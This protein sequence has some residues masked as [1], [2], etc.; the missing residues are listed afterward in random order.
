MLADERPE[1]DLNTI[2]KKASEDPKKI[3]AE[4]K[5]IKGLGDIGIDIFF[6]IAQHVWPCLGPWIDPRS[7]G[8]AEKI[9][10]GDEVQA[11]WKIVG[12]E[13]E[14]MCRLACALT[15]VRLER[16]ESEWA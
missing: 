5:T 6:T 7:L 3:R 14:A 4:L 15:D 9:G 10:L 16:K 8:T 12:Q 13:P 2:L 11:L 1:G